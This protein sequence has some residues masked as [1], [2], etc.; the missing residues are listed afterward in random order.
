MSYK[1]RP[2][3]KDIINN[4]RKYGPWKIQ[5]TIANNFIS[6]ID[7]DKEGIMHSKSDK[8]EFMIIDKAYKAIK[9]LFDSLKSRYQS[10]LE[11]MKVSELVFNYVDLL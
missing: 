2:Y 9:E 4:L 5:L 6:S 10:N 7:N 3:L 8:K 1:I 11:C